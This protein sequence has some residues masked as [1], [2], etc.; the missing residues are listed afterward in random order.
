MQ[1]CGGIQHVVVERDVI[2]RR[3]LLGQR[4]VT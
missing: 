3:Q 1:V 4:I 2:G